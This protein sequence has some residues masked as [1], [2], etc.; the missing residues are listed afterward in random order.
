[1]S[2]REKIGDTRRSSKGP[3][4]KFFC[5]VVPSFH[6]PVVPLSTLI[7]Y[8]FDMPRLSKSARAKGK[9]KNPRPK[10]LVRPAADA[11]STSGTSEKPSLAGRKRSRQEQLSQQPTKR[12]KTSDDGSSSLKGKRPYVSDEDSDEDVDY[13]QHQEVPTSNKRGRKKGKK[14]EKGGPTPKPSWKPLSD[15]NRRFFIHAYERAAS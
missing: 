7:Y 3:E 12:R 15:D 10:T 9:Q 13:E 2:C 6:F 1:L 5:C 8:S 14:T 4:N 11:G